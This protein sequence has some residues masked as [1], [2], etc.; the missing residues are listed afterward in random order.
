MNFFHI[1][2]LEKI[3]ESLFT[4]FATHQRKATFNLTFFRMIFFLFLSKRSTNMIMNMKGAVFL[5]V[6]ECFVS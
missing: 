3:R 1:K 4:I 6:E 2:N 5:F